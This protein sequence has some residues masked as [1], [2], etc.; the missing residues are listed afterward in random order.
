[1]IAEA[2]LLSAQPPDSAPAKAIHFRDSLVVVLALTTGAMDAVTY[3]RLG[4]VFSSVITGNLALL[5]VAA[6]QPNPGLAVNG[7][8]ALAGYGAGVLI[9]GAIAGIPDSHQP[10]WPRQVTAA[11]ATEL[12]MLAV[13]CGGWLAAAGHPSGGGRLAL[14][15]VAAAAMGMQ[16]TAVRRLGQMSTTYLTSTLTGLLHA[17][18]VRS[19]PS[20]WQRSTG[21]LAAFVVGAVLGAVAA[22]ESPS[23]VPAAVLI[24]L[25]A[26]VACS[27]PAA[28]KQTPRLRQ[29]RPLRVLFRGRELLSEK[30][31]QRDGKLVQF[32]QVCLGQLGDQIVAFLGELHPHHPGVLVV[33]PPADEPACFRS[34]DETHG[35]M[36]LQQQVIGDFPDGRRLR[37]RVPL[38]RHEQ[39][40]L[41]R[42][43]SHGGRL[44]LAPPQE[45]PQRHAEAQ[46]VPEDIVSRRDGTLL[47][48]R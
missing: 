41:G 29:T 16:S 2:A 43:E 33:R 5:G 20:E 48:P 21:V 4:K 8:L 35:A 1:M 37:A 25:A 9:G 17:M 10:V 34:V 12:L 36:P 30:H 3:L 46:V 14:L 23:L 42:G 27:L 40:V 47:S 11:L 24:P 15:V 26:V 44:L 45:A 28:V 13:L 32:A 39:L 19:W 31:R 7:G 38:D 6:G 18:A 22:L